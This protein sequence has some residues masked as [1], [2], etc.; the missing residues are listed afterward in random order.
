MIQRSLASPRSIRGLELRAHLRSAWSVVRARRATT[1][2]AVSL[3]A[4]G[5]ALSLQGAPL[6]WFGGSCL[7][8]S[9]ICVWHGYREPRLGAL[10]WLRR[11]RRLR[12]HAIVLSQLLVELI[13]VSMIL[14]VA[15]YMMRDL[16]AGVRP[17]SHDHT[18]HYFKAW[19]LHQDFL[20]RFRLHGFSHRWF[21]GYPV[22]Y[23]YPVGTDLFVNV[24]DY[25]TLGLVSFSRAYGLAF[26]LFHILTGYAGYRFGRM[27]GGPHVGLITGFLMI[28]DSSAFRFGG[29]AYTI[30]YGVWPQA[31]SLVFALLATTRVPAIY[32]TRSQRPLGMFALLMGASIVTHPMTL[33]YLGMLWVVSV[34]ASLF[35]PEVKTAV[36]TIRLLL[37]YALSVAVAAAWLLPFMSASKQTTPMGLWW[38]STYELGK[39]LIGLT[40]FPGTLGYVLAFGVLAS[41]VML[42]SRR[43]ALLLTALMA[44]AVP[45]LSNSSFIDDLHL[46]ALSEAFSKVQWLRMSTMVKPF[47]FAMAGYLVVAFLRVARDLVLPGALP[48]TEERERGSYVREVVFAMV[49]SFLTLPLAVP[50]AQAFFT[51]NIAKSMTTE[52]D[53]SLDGDRASLV[54]YL[55][56]NLPKGFYR[57]CVSTG[58]NHDLLD[59]GTEI[60]VPLYKRGFTPAENFIY[61]VNTEDN[62]VLEA[63]NVRYMIAKKWLPAEDYTLIKQ[64]GIYQLYEFKHWHSQPYVISDGAGTVRVERFEREQIVLDAAPGSHG[65]LRLNVSYFPRWHAYRDG[66][67]IALWP[68][69]LPEAPTTTGFM[70]VMLEPGH[71]RFAFE[72]SALDEASWP[73]S[74]IGIALSIALVVSGRIGSRW[75]RLERT[76]ARAGDLLEQVSRPRSMVFRRAMLGL[77]AAI[78]L[79]AVVYLGEWRPPMALEGLDGSVVSK[80]H[81]DFLDELSRAHVMIDYP[82]RIR[83]CRRL[84][85]RFVCKDEDGNLDNEK[86]VA[87][88]PAEIEEYRMVRCIR[89]RPEE[90]A[91]LELNFPEV[92][93]GDAIVGYYGVERAGRMLRLTRPVDFKIDVDG[94][95]IYSGATISDNKMHWFRADVGGPQRNVNVTFDVSAVNITRRFF[96][97]YAQMADL[98]S[99]V[100]KPPPRHATGELGDDEAN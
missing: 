42:R 50:A 55:K 6:W 63:V 58:H 4:I 78:A 98:H 56:H 45:A 79:A 8:G 43:F 82:T 15:L 5:L 95:Q 77:L 67:P 99:G 9:A 65:K 60:D 62:A 7:V 73:L 20:P 41:V 36:G 39:G 86:Y 93:S 83:R 92:P 49:V 66:K 87:S 24:I 75:P 2:S 91:R 57:V 23:L 48:A 76:L 29:W 69:A 74:L 85:S 89:A 90:N 35:V 12:G 3:F 44:F 19:Q 54:E 32:Q 27:I 38:D 22:D 97:F 68:T 47:W 37:A 94:Q 34:F 28:T 71:Y 59:I 52:L 51:A 30:E 46:P 72:E 53:R 84:G 88:S 16:F 13:Y 18:V 10:A 70:T 21:A 64:F 96:C 31:L 40:A 17:I 14:W 11:E 81:F 100:P 80:V 25:A 26:L 33:L 61:K 1:L